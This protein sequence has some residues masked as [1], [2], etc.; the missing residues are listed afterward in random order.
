MALLGQPF[1][2]LVRSY[3]GH[4]VN[5][6]RVFGLYLYENDENGALVC[7]ACGFAVRRAGYF[8]DGHSCC[9]HQPC[10]FLSL[11]KIE[12]SLSCLL[13]LLGSTLETDRAEPANICFVVHLARLRLSSLS[14][15]LAKHRLT[16]PRPRQ[17]CT[18]GQ[19]H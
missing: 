11:A 18:F 3:A 9:S 5:R 12:T 2:H 14:F 15:T 16:L 17:D 13:G 8:D 7:W 6:G 4:R 10:A 19:H 1:Y